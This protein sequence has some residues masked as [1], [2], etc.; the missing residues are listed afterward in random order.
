MIATWAE[1]EAVRLLIRAGEIA[2]SSEVINYNKEADRIILLA[3][4]IKAER[5]TVAMI[6]RAR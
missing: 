3:E 1:L 2:M 5:A 6:E 4:K